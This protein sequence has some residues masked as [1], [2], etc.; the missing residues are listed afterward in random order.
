MNK[1][2]NVSVLPA[3]V[4]TEQW[5][6]NSHENSDREFSLEHGQKLEIVTWN[7]NPDSDQQ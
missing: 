4:R 3:R 1:L 5:S 7:P 2:E 6:I